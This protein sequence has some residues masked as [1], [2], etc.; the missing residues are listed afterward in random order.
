MR[1]NRQG[2][3]V[4]GAATLV[5]GCAHGA[6]VLPKAVPDQTRSATSKASFPA[7]SLPAHPIVGEVRRFDG[8][9]P[10][11]SW[12]ICDG[13]ALPIEEYQPLYAVLGQSAA[14]RDPRTGRLLHPNATHFYLPDAR[15]ERFVIAVRGVA[16]TSPSVV[17]AVMNRR[18]AREN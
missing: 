13:R 18:S 12:M 4:G 7:L 9:R 5:A 3:V 1:M 15:P 6:G 2:F 10:P 17:N 8:K 11:A 14:P 16:P